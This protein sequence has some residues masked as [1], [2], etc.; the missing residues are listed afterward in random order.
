MAIVTEV[1]SAKDVTANDCLWN[2]W[3]IIKIIG[4][5]G[6]DSKGDHYS[7]AGHKGNA[8]IELIRG[9]R[10]SSFG[11][12]RPNLDGTQWLKIQRLEHARHEGRGK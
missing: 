2:V 12:R 9:V 7:G 1:A 11:R 6:Q 3:A 5:N 4:N 8:Y 10:L